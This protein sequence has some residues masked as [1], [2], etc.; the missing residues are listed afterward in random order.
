MGRI[1]KGLLNAKIRKADSADI[2]IIKECAREAFAVYAERIGR[3]PAPMVVD[4]ATQVRNGIVFVICNELVV[5]G[6]VV[7]YPRG[8]RIHL[9]NVAVYPQYMGYGFGRILITYVE[10]QARECGFTFVELYTNLKM[11]GNLSLYPKLGYFETDRSA[12]DGFDSV[13]FSKTL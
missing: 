1:E 10:N 7:F 3:E 4:F 6:Y 9:E 11:F 5:F 2:P 12:E 8:D 13:Y